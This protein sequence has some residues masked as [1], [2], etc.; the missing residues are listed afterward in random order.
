MSDPTPSYG[1]R[2]DAFE[3]YRRHFAAEAARALDYEILV[4]KASHEPADGRS[5][6]EHAMQAI[7]TAPDPSRELDLAFAVVMR[8]EQIKKLRAALEELRP[9]V[10]KYCPSGIPII[11]KA[12][13]T[14]GGS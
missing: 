2:P 3:T 4:G 11:D 6:S 9:R 8:G 7:C 10:V 13:G 14:Q 1:A 5:I 12:L